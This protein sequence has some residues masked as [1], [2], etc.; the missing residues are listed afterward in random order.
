MVDNKSHSYPWDILSLV[1][2]IGHFK[3]QTFI[4]VPKNPL[5]PL[6]LLALESK[7]NPTLSTLHKE[8][9][10]KRDFQIQFS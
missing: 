7:E 9:G 6:V 4:N 2:S 1:F 3:L 8:R 10:R 5:T